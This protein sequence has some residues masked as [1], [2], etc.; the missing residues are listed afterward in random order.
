M[1]RMIA[2]P[3]RSRCVGDQGDL[4]PPNGE[5]MKNGKDA[6]VERSIGR[7]ATRPELSS[8]ASA[9]GVPIRNGY[10]LL[11]LSSTVMRAF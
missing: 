10:S 9:R 4:R 11:V 5:M 3:R 7:S 2:G 6:D 8:S 1:A